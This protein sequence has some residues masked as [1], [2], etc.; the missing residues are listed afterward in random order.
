MAKII[1]VKQKANLFAKGLN[2][3]D[4]KTGKLADFTTHPNSIR[5][6]YPRKSQNGEWI[7][8]LSEKETEEY[9]KRLRKDLTP[10]SE[11]W[12]SLEMRLV[13]KTVEVTFN[14]DN[15]LQFIQYKCA[16]ANKFLA[17][18]IEQLKE[19]AFYISDSFLY[20]YDPEGDIKREN[21][22]RELKDECTAIIFNM[23]TQKERMFYILAKTGAVV[24]ESWTPGILYKNLSLYLDG[25]KKTEQLE[26]YKEILTTDNESLQI[27]YLVKKSFGKEITF[28]NGQWVFGGN[29]LGSSKDKVFETFTKK[30]DLFVLLQ[31]EVGTLL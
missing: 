31:E 27:E 19:P 6:Y 7:T 28:M 5:S 16:I 18:N 10:S 22:L 3:I 14:L 11:F 17:E 13:N 1:Q 2:Q 29:S 12:E 8:G 9:G 4:E 26:N 21:G 30:P 25:M 23:R 20:V 24:N 15:P